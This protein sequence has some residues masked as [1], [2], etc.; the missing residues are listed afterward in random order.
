M[1][2]KK[3][4][5]GREFLNL[6]HL[7]STSSNIA[8]KIEVQ[9]WDEEL[10]KEN[11]CDRA[12]VDFEISDCSKRISLDFDIFTEEQMTNSLHKIDVM[13]KTLLKMK[14][15]LVSARK[16]IVKGIARAEYY[17][18]KKKKEKKD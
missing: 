12:D 6:P 2:I 13:V 5:Y 11:L 9:T 17:N 3:I 16:E 15:D 10:K 18:E 1:L 14:K 7:V 8:Y 4:G